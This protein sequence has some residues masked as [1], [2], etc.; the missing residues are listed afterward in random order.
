[1]QVHSELS[2]VDI[3]QIVPDQP[4][5]VVASPVGYSTP[6]GTLKRC[7]QRKYRPNSLTNGLKTLGATQVRFAFDFELIRLL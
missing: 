3:V 6:Q 1:M 4:A 7:M 5:I 2:D